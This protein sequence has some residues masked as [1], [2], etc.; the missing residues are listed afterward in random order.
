MRLSA[1][2]AFVH[3]KLRKFHRK[4][5][6]A[7]PW[8]GNTLCKA[9]ERL[10]AVTLHASLSAILLAGQLTSRSETC[11]VSSLGKRRR[12]PYGQTAHLAHG[13]DRQALQR[14]YR[15]F[16]R[17][18]IQ[19]V[20]LQD[21]ASVADAVAWWTEMTA[22]GREGMVV[23]PLNF[24]AEGKRGITQ[25]AIKCRGAEYLRIIYGPE[26]L[27]PEILNGCVL[28]MSEPSGL[29][30]VQSLHLASRRWSDSFARSPYVSLMNASSEFLH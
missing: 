26:Y 29:S 2:L 23:K 4:G 11:S 8:L 19:I 22:Q 30:Q 9:T 25:P 28:G 17:N 15:D 12:S 7:C 5:Y 18:P 10:D 3:Y 14:G 6:A 20:D 13:D 21:E 16:T 1:M 24:I 27:L